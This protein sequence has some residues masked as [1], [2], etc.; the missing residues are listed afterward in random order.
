MKK[1]LAAQPPAATV[2]GLQP[3]LNRFA[4][5]YK[6]VRP[7]RALNRRTPLQ[8]YQDRP[9]AVPTGLK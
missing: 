1:W 7:H 5:Y 8:A 6:T 3:Q 2:A 4:S 9:N